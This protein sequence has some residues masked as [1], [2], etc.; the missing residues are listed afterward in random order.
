M[1]QAKIDVTSRNGRTSLKVKSNALF[2]GLM[3]LH[4]AFITTLILMGTLSEKGM[5]LLAAGLGAGEVPLLMVTLGKAIGTSGAVVLGDAAAIDAVLQFARAYIYTTAMPPAVAAASIEAVRI[6]RSEGERRERLAALIARFRAGAAALGLTALPSETAIQP[7]LIGDAGRA[8]RIATRLG[9]F[10]EI[11]HLLAPKIVEV[12]MNFAF[13]LFPDSG[14]A[15]GKKERPM[16]P[17]P[18]QIALAQ[19]TRGIHW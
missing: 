18:E 7:L 8:L 11:S 5:G 1:G 13:N 12:G 15:A 2:Q 6:A 16:E 14:A 19:I 9:I 10:A 4:P 3:T 17:S